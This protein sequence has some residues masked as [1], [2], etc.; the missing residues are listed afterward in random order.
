MPISPLINYDM[1]VVFTRH[2]QLKFEILAAHGFKL[3]KRE[4]EDIVNMPQRL[5]KT[6]KGRLIAQSEL[7]DTHVIRVVYQE[8]ESI[9]KIITF[10][11]ARRQ[12]YED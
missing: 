8:E 2:A 3:T 9:I 11:P 5:I 6:R 10:Y 4:I 1:N 12:R 7:N